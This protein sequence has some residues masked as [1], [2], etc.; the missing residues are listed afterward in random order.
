MRLP[1]FLDWAR[2]AR[3]SV[4][5]GAVVHLRREQRGDAVYEIYAAESAESARR[6]L[7]SRRV[8]RARFYLCVRTPSQGHWGLDVE[9]LFLERL[10]DWQREAPREECVDGRIGGMP[11]LFGLR[12]AAQHLS[13]NFIAPI[14]CGGCKRGWLDGVA[15]ADMTLV[16]CPGCG[17][18][19]RIRTDELLLPGHARGRR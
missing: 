1:A 18:L 19:N 9:G 3:A 8:D 13:D 6:F 14:E 7:S 4:D 12:A 15:Y 2:R 5:P 16:R 10:L 17:R 11:C